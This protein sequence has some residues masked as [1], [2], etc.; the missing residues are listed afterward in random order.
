MFLDEVMEYIQR[1]ITRELPGDY[2]T[3]VVKEELIKSCLKGWGRPM[4]EYLEAVNGLMNAHMKRLVNIHFG[5]HIHSGLHAKVMSIVREQLRLVREKTMLHLTSILSV[6]GL[7][8]TLNHIYLKEYKDK[9]LAHY[10]DIRRRSK[11]QDVIMRK[12][13]ESEGAMVSTQVRNDLIDITALLERLGLPCTPADLHR[14]LPDDELESALDIIA[15][16]RA[17]FQVAFRRFIDLVPL[18]IDAEFI[19]AFET[20]IRPA[21][22]TGLDVRSTDRCSLWLQDAPEVLSRRKELQATKQRLDAARVELST[23]AL[24]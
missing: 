8:F 5:M 10:K 17:Y 7:P 1:A 21:L 20:T 13:Q 14:L 18:I 4:L 9:F 16:V 24:P 22:I 3:S 23:F 19:M 11:G 12:F 15:S 6:E 2:P